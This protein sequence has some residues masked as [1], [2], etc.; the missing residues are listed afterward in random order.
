MALGRAVLPPILGSSM[1]RGFW[2]TGAICFA[3]FV[4]VAHTSARAGPQLVVMTQNMDEGTDY[5]ALAAAT[6][7]SVAS[8]DDQPRLKDIVPTA[9]GIA[10][11]AA[12]VCDCG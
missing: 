12:K 9:V 4:L 6:N 10:S 11:W 1:R 3:L 8:T 7:A 2:T 5:Q